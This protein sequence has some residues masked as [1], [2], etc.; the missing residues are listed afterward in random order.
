[1]MAQTISEKKPVTWSDVVGCTLAAFM[2]ISL[3][4]VPP[5]AATRIAHLIGGTVGLALAW[6][7]T[8]KRGHIL[9]L[10][11]LPIITTLGIMVASIIRDFAAL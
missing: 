5:V 3:V 8:R 7:L 2:I 6:G 10:L 1:M 9:T 4:V 11:L